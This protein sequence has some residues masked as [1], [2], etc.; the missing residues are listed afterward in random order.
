MARVIWKGAISFGLVHIPVNLHPGATS[1]GLDFDLLDKRDFAPVGYQRVN[2]RTGKE[3]APDEIV[4]GYEYAKGEYV[5]VSDTDFR[6]ANVK[7]TQTVEIRAFVD[8]REIAP[9]YFDTPYYLEPGKRAAK[10]YALL[11]E[12]LR[13]TGRAGVATVVLRARQHLAVLMPVGRLLVLNTLRFADELRPAARLALPGENLKKAGVSAKELELAGRLVADMTE[14]WRPAAYKDTYRKDL[15]ARIAEKV[16][17]G[18]T[19][20]VGGDAEREPRQRG[21]QVID[22]MAALKKSL[23]KGGG[24]ARKGTRR[25]APRRAGSADRRRA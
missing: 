4:K 9:C 3:V 16:K 25:R 8:A 22:L 14:P 20:E 23:G 15:L 1:S 5:V 11:R 24:A 6:E 2:K 21:A 17:R 18:A 19:H 12:T 7:A 13:R 10:G